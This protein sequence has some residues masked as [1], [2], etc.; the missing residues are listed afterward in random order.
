MTRP[1]KE[2]TVLLLKR[3]LEKAKG[4]SPSD[5]SEWTRTARVTSIRVFGDPSAQ[6]HEFSGALAFRTKLGLVRSMLDEVESF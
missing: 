1:S 5:D 2:E 3:L 6:V 4:T